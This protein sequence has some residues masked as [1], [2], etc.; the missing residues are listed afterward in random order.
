MP[1][2]EHAVQASSK[3]SADKEDF[4]FQRCL[5]TIALSL[6]ACFLLHASGELAQFR[7]PWIAQEEG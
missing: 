2:R 7:E 5:N 1:N 6:I 4:L 3:D